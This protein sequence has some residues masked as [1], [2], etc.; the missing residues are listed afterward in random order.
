MLPLYPSHSIDPAIADTA[1]AQI[2]YRDADHTVRIQDVIGHLQAAGAQVF[3]VG[4]ACRDWLTGA[5]S[6]DLDLAIDRPLDEAHAILRRAWPAIDPVLRRFERFGMLRW[7]DAGSGGVDLNILRSPR[8]ITHDNM[9]TTTFVSRAD[10]R[11]DALTRDFSC[12][13]F[14]Y[15]CAARGHVLDPLAVGLA[16]VHDRVLRLIADPRVL[17][18]SFSTTCR[19]LQFV[20]RGYAPAANVTAYLARHADRDVQRMGGEGLLWWTIGHFAAAERAAFVDDVRAHVRAAE[21]HAVLDHVRDHMRDAL[22]RS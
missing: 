21:A 16:D 9:F 11:D 7:G 19:I 2:A 20:R 10:L 4:G 13:A 6:K 3:V 14:Y 8:D 1:L 12:N 15:P 5:P 22:S 17:E 18:T